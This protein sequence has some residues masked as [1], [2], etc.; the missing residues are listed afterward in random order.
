DSVQGD[1]ALWKRVSGAQAA[2]STD[3]SFHSGVYEAGERLLAVNRSPAEALAPV[4]ADAKLAQLFRGLDFAR[5][6]DRAGSIGSLIQEI[7]RVFLVSMMI[8]MLAE[9]A[10]C[11]PKVARSRGLTA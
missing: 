6:D 2:L 8:A 9:A 1:P 3:Y 4:V 7:W 11:L 5:V 10:L